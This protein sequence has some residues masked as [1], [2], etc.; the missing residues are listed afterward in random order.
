[1]VMTR[2][3]IDRLFRQLAMSQ[4]FYGRLR[5]RDDYE[6]ILDSIESAG[7]EDPVSLIIALEG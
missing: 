5:A 4:G 1:M 3:D 7:F 6:D 2:E